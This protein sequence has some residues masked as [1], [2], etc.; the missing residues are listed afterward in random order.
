MSKIQ[1]ATHFMTNP[2][3]ASRNV[4]L[5]HWA[6][7]HPYRC[8]NSNLANARQTSVYRCVCN[9][10]DSTSAIN[11]P[12]MIP[13]TR[14]SIMSLYSP[15]TSV[16]RRIQGLL[17]PRGTTIMSS[18]RTEWPDKGPGLRKLWRGS[19]SAHP[20]KPHSVANNVR[21]TEQ[22]LIVCMKHS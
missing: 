13:Y 14:Q 11:S 21:V 20:T 9:C 8:T 5:E 18:L 17:A 3:E 7:N 10:P 4:T 22:N 15:L 2:C 19:C 6:I 16:S 12:S 1:R